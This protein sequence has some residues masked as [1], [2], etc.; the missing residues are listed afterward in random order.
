MPWS[1]KVHILL[2]GPISNEERMR[3]A[4]FFRH[5]DLDRSPIADSQRYGFILYYTD[6]VKAIELGKRQTRKRCVGTQVSEDD[7]PDSQNFDDLF[8]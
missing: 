3:V 2:E 5:C 8:V 7:F 4:D 6:F 1:R